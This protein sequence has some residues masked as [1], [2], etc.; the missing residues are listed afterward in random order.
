MPAPVG[1]S[2]RGERPPHLR[3]T[4]KRG[5]AFGAPPLPGVDAGPR[6]AVLM[7]AARKRRVAR[8]RRIT[9][10]QLRIAD[11]KRR[12]RIAYASVSFGAVV[13]G[14]LAAFLVSGAL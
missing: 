3:V 10:Q 8:Q 5:G 6:K 11:Y 9:T 12:S 7:I 13:F 4:G 14:A 1:A 2:R